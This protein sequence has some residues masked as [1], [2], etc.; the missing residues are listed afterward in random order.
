MTNMTHAS[1]DRTEME[2]NFMPVKAGK[3]GKDCGHECSPLTSSA[4][5]HVEFPLRETPAFQPKQHFPD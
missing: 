1:N 3:P 4:L 5:A 2:W